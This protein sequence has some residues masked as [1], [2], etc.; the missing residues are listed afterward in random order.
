MG[1]HAI[2]QPY[3]KKW[4]N[5]LDTL[6]FANLAIINGISTYIYISYSQLDEGESFP[7]TP[8]QCIL[9]VLIY[10]P[11]VYIV[12]YGLLHLTKRLR[13]TRKMSEIFLF[14]KKHY[15][16]L[17]TTEYYSDNEIPARLL[18]GEFEN[19]QSFNESFG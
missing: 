16:Y 6:I 9:L 7:V 18:S 14:F 10:L 3:Q 12:S 2:I 1:T 4:H 19:Y 5:I 15:A 17:N 8:F 13:K 11:M